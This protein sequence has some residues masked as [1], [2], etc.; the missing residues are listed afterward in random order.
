MKRGARRR[1]RSRIRVYVRV[2]IENTLHSI[3]TKRSVL[4]DDLLSVNLKTHPKPEDV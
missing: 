1:N 3:E 4:S 2:E